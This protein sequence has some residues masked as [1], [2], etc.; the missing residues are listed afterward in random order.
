[1]RTAACRRVVRGTDW[2][3][4]DLQARYRGW[5]AWWL[6]RKIIQAGAGER[7]VRPRIGSILGSHGY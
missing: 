2:A 1:M 4:A 3:R 6:Q 7:S 5:F